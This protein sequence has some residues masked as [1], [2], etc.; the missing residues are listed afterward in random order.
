MKMGAASTAAL[1]FQEPGTKITMPDASGSI[2]VY[3][4]KEKTARREGGGDGRI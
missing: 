4:E 1:R 3:F 2:I